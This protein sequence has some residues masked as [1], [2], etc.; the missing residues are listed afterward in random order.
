MNTLEEDNLKIEAS[1]KSNLVSFR[2][3]ASSLQNWKARNFYCLYYFVM[4]NLKK[5]SI[6]TD[7]M[8]KLINAEGFRKK[9][10]DKYQIWYEQNLS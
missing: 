5:T 7:E 9:L 3:W 8:K 2:T 4:E 10:L 6:Y 1:E